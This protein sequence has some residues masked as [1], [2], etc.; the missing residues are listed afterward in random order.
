MFTLGRNTDKITGT[1]GTKKHM[2]FASSF[3]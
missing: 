1:G 2:Q 3:M